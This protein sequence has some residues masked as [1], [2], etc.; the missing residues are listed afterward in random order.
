MIHQNS[1]YGGMLRK[2]LSF[3][4]RKLHAGPPTLYVA[5]YTLECGHQI[6]PKRT[7]EPGAHK[8]FRCTDC[9]F[10]LELSDEDIPF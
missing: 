5:T 10:K 2:V 8:E 4:S 7:Y 3:S 6:G 1:R 9:G